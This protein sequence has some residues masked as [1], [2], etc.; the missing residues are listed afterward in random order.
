MDEETF[1]EGFGED[2]GAAVNG[3]DIVS[4]MSDLGWHR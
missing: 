3:K 4:I 1:G 2:V